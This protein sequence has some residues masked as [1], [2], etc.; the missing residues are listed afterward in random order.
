M[1]VAHDGKAW[2][3][4]LHRLMKPITI[5]VFQSLRARRR[6][7][8]IKGCGD[9][10]VIFAEMGKVI[11]CIHQP[12]CISKHADE[13]S[14]MQLIETL[15]LDKSGIQFGRTRCIEHDNICLTIDK[16]LGKCNIIR[17]KTCEII[18]YSLGFK[19]LAQCCSESTFLACSV[20]TIDKYRMTFTETFNKSIY[21]GVYQPCFILIYLEDI[22]VICH[23]I[24]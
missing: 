17:L 22:A 3:G 7:I 2:Q 4:L 20:S 8:I 5:A 6:G 19:L 18:A 11:R 1:V 9:I 10:S 21:C 16:S 14:W 24:S 13:C 12:F 23:I 15:K